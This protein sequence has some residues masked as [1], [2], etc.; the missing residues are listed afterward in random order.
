MSRRIS[1]IVRIMFSFV[2]VVIFV[3]LV[4]PSCVSAKADGALPSSIDLSTDPYYGSFFPQ[5]GYQEGG[6]C[7]S[8][9]TTYYQFTYEVARL[10][11]WNVKYS[12]YYKFSPKYV[13]DYV[14]YGDSSVGSELSDCYKVLQELGSVR[15]SEFD[16]NPDLGDNSWFIITTQDGN[17]NTVMN[18]NATVFS[19]RTALKTRITDYYAEHIVTHAQNET[20]TTPDITSFDDSDLIGIKTKLSQGHVLVIST[21]VRS[22]T[23]GT[24]DYNGD[25]DGEQIVLKVNGDNGDAHAVT[26]VGYDDNIW[27]D[28]NGNDI[29]ED[30]EKGAFKLANS[31]GTLWRNDGF[32]WVAYDALNAVSNY[33]DP[34]YF[35]RTP[36]FYEYE[37]NYI[38]V[39]EFAPQLTVGFTITQSNRAG[40]SVTLCRNSYPSDITS[41]TYYDGSSCLGRREYTG[42]NPPFVQVPID[43]DGNYGQ[44]AAPTERMFILDCSNDV[45]Y[46]GLYDTQDPAVYSIVISDLSADNRSTYISEVVWR[47]SSGN[48][49]DSNQTSVSLDGTSHAYQ[50]GTLITSVSLNTNT[51]PTLLVGYSA[52]LTAT[53]LPAN[54]TSGVLWIS[55]NPNIATV[56][57][58]GVVTSVGLGSTTIT[59]VAK[60]GSGYSASCSLITT[61]YMYGNIIY[62]NKNQDARRV[63]FKFNAN[64]V[65]SSVTIHIGSREFN[66]TRPQSGAF[67]Q[68][69][70]NNRVKVI[71]T[72]E[73]QSTSVEWDVQIRLAQS[74]IAGGTE[75]I[76]IEFSDGTNTTRNFSE[77]GFVFWASSIRGSV[78]E[79]MSTATLMEGYELNLGCDCDLYNSFTA[80]TSSFQYVAT[81]LAVAIKYDNAYNGESSIYEIVYVVL[82]GDVV[83]NGVIGDCVIGFEDAVA[84]LRHAAETQL[85]N[86]A[87]IKLAADVDHDGDITVSDAQTIMDYYYDMGTINQSYCP[88]VP[89]D[90]CFGNNTVIFA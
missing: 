54:A 61:H 75:T 56:D 69:I 71:F 48:V 12:N 44:D 77:Y 65:Y 36:A 46:H 15:Y 45:A 32:V 11:N 21:F 78:Y 50:Y 22:F 89:D 62:T 14:N 88:P 60:D 23:V 51:L 52:Q 3:A 58:N 24:L 49:L 73:V 85:L 17:G 2:V 34:S 1:S 55:S 7:A 80:E 8:W 27:Y 26:I 38:D 47:N 18:Y 82:Y 41:G 57:S 90:V 20:V 84:V 53:I 39:A 83:G 28:F 4:L 87:L 74:T 76:W 42:G 30:W 16:A 63:Q 59:A 6:S 31:W 10:K 13:Y 86:G 5:I 79:T 9:A 33:S 72:Q 68:W 81:G 66:V 70:D 29:A 37:Y 35:V 64:E 25:Y 19:L 40:Y 67:D 43:F